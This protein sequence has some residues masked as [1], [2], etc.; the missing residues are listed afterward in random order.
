M[1]PILLELKDLS[2]Q[3]RTD[4]ETVY[5]VTNLNLTLSP[6]ETIG[7]V[8]ETGAGKTSTALA[9][10][11]LLPKRTGRVTSGEVMTSYSPGSTRSAETR[12]FAILMTSGIFSAI[13]SNSSGPLLP[14]REV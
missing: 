11:G 9:V 10:M 2:V 6:G 1:K 13:L 8:G 4:L 7:L 12:S 3:Y 14:D 5:A